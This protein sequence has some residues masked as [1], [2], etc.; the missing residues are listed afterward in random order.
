MT[1]R[2]L[3]S[4]REVAILRILGLLALAVMVLH[5]GALR[6]SEEFPVA[7]PPLTPDIFP[8]SSCHAGMEPDMKKR[9]LSM[10]TEVK[11]RHAPEVIKWCFACH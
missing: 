1:E 6:A 10:H 5:S 8:C 11:L 3:P 7:P 4:R 2:C 9:E